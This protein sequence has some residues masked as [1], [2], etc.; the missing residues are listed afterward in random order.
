MVVKLGLSRDDSASQLCLEALRVNK[1]CFFFNRTNA[2]TDLPFFELNSLI[3]FLPLINGLQLL[4]Q[5]LR[6]NKG[7]H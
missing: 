3:L 1:T 7:G 4:I 5:G 2:P 6:C